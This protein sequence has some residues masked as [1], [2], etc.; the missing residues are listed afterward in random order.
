[1]PFDLVPI[2]TVILAVAV[3]MYVLL[4]GFDLGVGIL[5]PFM[6]DEDTLSGWCTPVA[7]FW[8][9][10]EQGSPLGAAVR[11]GRFRPASSSFILP[12]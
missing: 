7:P 2:W 5:F 3:F 10:P 1:M 6:R 4:D 9:A 11:S 8:N 12:S